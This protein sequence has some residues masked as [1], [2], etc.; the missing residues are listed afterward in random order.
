MVGYIVIGNTNSYDGDVTGNHSPNW[1]EVDIWV[2]KLSGDGQLLWEHCFGSSATDRFWGINSVLKIDDYDYVIGANSDYANGDVTCDLFPPPY[3]NN[4]NAW[5]FEIKDCSYYLPSAPVIQ[6]GPDTICTIGAPESSYSIDTVKWASGYEWV[7]EPDS[8]GSILSDSTLNRVTWNPHFEG[9]VS[10]KARSINDCGHSEWSEP[11]LTQVYTCLGLDEHEGGEAGKLG[12]LE[13]WPNPAKTIVNCHLSIVDCQGDCL[14][15]IYDIYGRTVSAQII[16]SPMKG[17]GR[18][19]GW[20]GRQDWT[21]D[22]S[23][24]PSGIYFVSVV[25]DGKHIAGSKFVVAH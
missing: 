24:L 23:S 11:Y 9:L 20:Q 19:G 15:V 3:E 22:V 16:T 10:I 25:Q 7:I 13:L 14:L 18:E 8:A 21:F 5:I 6:S 2:V 4:S 17:G 12:C 1:N